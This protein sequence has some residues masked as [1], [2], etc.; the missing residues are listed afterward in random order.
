M[1]L[2]VEKIVEVP[3]IIVKQVPY[4]VVIERQIII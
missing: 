4:E 2:V 3:K 1:E